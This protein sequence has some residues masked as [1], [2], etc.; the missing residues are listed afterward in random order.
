[1]IYQITNY[2]IRDKIYESENSAI[3]RGIRQPDNQ[4]VILK[5]QG[6]EYPGAEKL[7]RYQ[8]E[9][10]ILRQLDSVEGVIKAYDLKEFDKN[11]VII[12][13][14]F[15]ALSLKEWF[16]QQEKPIGISKFLS[17][18]KQLAVILS[19]IHLQK[20]IHQDINPANILLNPETEQVKIIDFGILAPL[21]TDTIARMIADTLHTDGEL[22]QPLA[23]IVAQKTGGN[24]FF[25]REFFTTLHKEQ[26]ISFNFQ[27]LAWQWDLG[28]I[29]ST[30]IAANVAELGIAKLCQ[31]PRATQFVL[32]LAGCTGISFDLENLAAISNKPVATIAANLEAAIES[33]LIF[34][35]SSESDKGTYK[36]LHDC[37]QQA[38][39][40]SMS[41]EE[42]QAIHLAIGRQLWQNTPL[43]DL[44]ENIFAI[45]D[46]LN[47]GIQ[48][49]TDPE[50]RSQIA[51]L[52]A[53]AAKKAL[54][55]T[56]YEAAATYCQ[57][58]IA[59]LAQDSWF[60]DYETT[61]SLYLQAIEAEFSIGNFQRAEILS[62]II[63]ERVRTILD[64]V[65]VYQLR[66][67]FYIAQNQLKAALV[68]G[69]ASLEMLGIYLERKPPNN[70]LELDLE[71]LP[72][73]TEPSQLAAMKILSGIVLAAQ[74][75]N[76]PLFPSIIYTM[77]DLCLNYGNSTYA[78]LAYVYHGL[79]L[80]HRLGDWSSG[81]QQGELALRL[82]DQFE[83][84]A[85][86]P[87]VEE[88]F[89]AFI[90][91]RQ[92]LVRETIAD[93]N[94]TVQSGL[95]TGQI[96]WACYG[97]S[98]YCAHL[99]LVGEPLEFVA[100]QQQEYLDLIAQLKQEFKLD[101][102]QIWSQLVE[103]LKGESGKIFHR[104]EMAGKLQ[105]GNNL[106]S[107]FS[108]YLTETIFNYLLRNYTQAQASAIEAKLYYSEA[109][110][111]FPEL[112]LPFYH[113]LT[114][115]ALYPTVQESQQ[116]DYLKQVIAYLE[117]IKIAAQF[118]PMN[119]QH[120]YDLVAAERARVLEQNWQAAQLYEKAITGAKTN[121]YLQ[122]EALAYELAA[123][124][125]LARG[126]EKIG[127]TYLID[128]RDRYNGWQAWA[129]VKDLAVKYSQ[130]EGLWAGSRTKKSK[131]LAVTKTNTTSLDSALDLA[132]VMKVSLA[133]ADEILLDKLLAKLMQILI[134]NA[135]ARKGFLILEKS[136]EML[137]QAV[138]EA[139]AN[140]K[141]QQSMAIENN[142]PSSIINYVV[143]TGKTIVLN[144]GARLGNFT[145][146]P[147][148]RKHQSKSILCYS[149]LHQGKLMGIVYLENNLTYGAFT[150]DR[151][152]VLKLLSGQA[153]IAIANAQLYAEVREAEKLLQEYN[154]TLEQQVAE[155]TQEL[156]RKNKELETVLE[157]RKEAELA[158]GLSEEKFAK[159]FRSSPNSM[160]I[161][162]RKDGKHLEVND[163][164]CRAIG[165]P[166]EEIIGRTAME[167]NFWINLEDRDRLFM[168]INKQG[169]VNNY[170]FQ[171]RNKSGQVRTGLLSL[172]II[173]LRG[174][175]CLLSIANDITDRK[176][177]EQALELKNIELEATL[178]HLEVTQEELIEAEKMAALGQLVAGVAHEINTPLGAITS[179]IRNI[180]NFWHE[181]LKEFLCFWPTLSRERKMGFFSLLVKARPDNEFL[182]TREKRQMKKKFIRQL[183]S[184]SVENAVAI[185]QLLVSMGIQTNLELFVPLLTDKEGEKLFQLA[186]EFAKVQT[187]IRIITTAA[188]RAEKVVFALKFY[189]RQPAGGEKV[190]ANL[191]EGIETILTMYSNQLKQGVEIM[192]KYPEKLEEIPCY[193]EELNQVWT[194][195]IYNALQAMN[196]QG[197]LTIEVKTKE[198]VEGKDC[199][200]QIAVAI[201]D[202]GSGIPAEIQGKIFDPFF[203]TK[204]PGEGSGLG[205]NIVSKI[206]AKHDGTIEVESVPGKTT[207]TALIPIYSSGQ[208]IV[209][210]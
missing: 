56:A 16:N 168:I 52:N 153:V 114:L 149:L 85:I 81:Y 204:P 30:D 36:F 193:P 191:I 48:L 106:I 154:L 64:K 46:R 185:A 146:D 45:V 192:R 166:R 208:L 188:A 103:Q 169:A 38:A 101:Y 139:E 37:I 14:D 7:A 53:T 21:N 74:I 107:L 92:Q 18:A 140:I 177:A 162:S 205:L 201:T 172:E 43:E 173:N 136:G 109:G 195:L 135:G 29:A 145:R 164:F 26:L 125:Y 10:Q 189:A 138:G 113:A 49:V 155:R 33:G 171:F 151:L 184:Y 6:L 94:S 110:G 182:S 68:N 150:P 70:W 174:E 100:S 39:Y 66:I 161:T 99:F 23:T 141:V 72:M 144:D 15:G 86:R 83:T 24:P 130:I 98:N 148:I 132:A 105:Q 17:L 183:Q 194:N 206:M 156:E 123:E 187:S 207:F 200:K 41:Q 59:F 160:T 42:Q 1:M 116:Q 197:T 196:N 11:I 134:E 51:R 25:I 32:S 210:S 108:L 62:D 57:T 73:M 89:Y 8:Q 119:Y 199:C 4:A 111:L 129:K 71:N 28:E 158:L 95:E 202:T 96:E 137:I 27:T 77:V 91:H 128:A 13:E 34:P 124:F 54:N 142:L 102:T 44:T 75:G 186:Y 61:V 35:E 118:A 198:Q 12:L 87:Q 90:A 47:Q 133:I 176:Q 20:I 22:T 58:G 127:Q 55:T 159:A 122:E 5:V 9:Y 165:Y 3:Y 121:H 79:L 60:A 170:E 80:C 179:S 63:L 167:L 209:D 78:P 152:K 178:E 40:S 67:R 112:Q 31:L 157:K 117:E 69:L 180:D 65:K 115:L 120:Q 126:M 82:L 97:A 190:K 76:P 181:N 147:Y 175:E 2:T 88:L 143:R 50:E 163:S 203:T 84:R 104:D 93:L 131:G 19:Q